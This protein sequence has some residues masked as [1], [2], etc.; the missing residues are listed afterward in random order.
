MAVD[1]SSS[2]SEESFVQYSPTPGNAWGLKSG[3]ANYFQI[4]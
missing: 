2:N 4:M 1:I 3:M